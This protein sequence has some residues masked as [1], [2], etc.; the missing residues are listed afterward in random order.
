MY[1]IGCVVQPTS[2]ASNRSG[3][4][5][6]PKY[7]TEVDDISSAKQDRAEIELVKRSMGTEVEVIE[8][9]MVQ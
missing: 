5:K 3:E 4:M 6:S 2:S 8:C 7:S 1:K 9:H